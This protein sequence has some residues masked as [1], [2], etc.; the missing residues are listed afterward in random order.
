MIG[1]RPC[2]SAAFT[3]R[4]TVSSVSPKNWRRSL[5][6]M[7]TYCAR[8]GDLRDADFAG[9]RALLLPVHVLRADARSS[10]RASAR[11]TSCRNTNGGQTIFSTPAMPS[12]RSRS[13]SHSASASARSV[14]IFQLPAMIG[15]RDI[16]RLRT[17]SGGRA[18]AMASDSTSFAGNVPRMPCAQAFSLKP[19]RCVVRDRSLRVKQERHGMPRVPGHDSRRRVV[20]RRP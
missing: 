13:A 7:M 5:W 14:F 19:S 1:F 10:I 3:R 17:S 2:A 20:A 6:P 15:V 18:C 12:T 4:F 9:E 16:V 11:C 8:L